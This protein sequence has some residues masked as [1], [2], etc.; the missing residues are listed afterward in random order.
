MIIFLRGPKEIIESGKNGLL[1]PVRDP[2][3]LAE[4]II[5][6]IDNPNEANC[7]AKNSMKIRETHSPTRINGIWEKYLRHIISEN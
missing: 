2:Y 1:V 5:Y 6:L 7:L 4:A 3:K